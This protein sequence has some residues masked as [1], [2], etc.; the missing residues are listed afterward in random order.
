MKLSLKNDNH[1]TERFLMKMY[2]KTGLMLVSLVCLV[3]CGDSVNTKREEV[4]RCQAF[5]IGLPMSG[6]FRFASAIDQFLAE[7]GITAQQTLPM[8]AAAQQYGQNMDA[9]RVA[10]ISEE[11]VAKAK[12]MAKKEDITGAVAYATSCVNNFKELGKN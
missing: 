10:R 9:A 11:G 6:N 3:A 12:E 8:S 2:G 1:S 5:F 7:G 4:I